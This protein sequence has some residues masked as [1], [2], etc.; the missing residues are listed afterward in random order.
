MLKVTRNPSPAFQA[1]SWLILI[2]GLALALL[3]FPSRILAIPSF[4]HL[5]PVLPDTWLAATVVI[6]FLAV[7]LKL[8]RAAPQPMLTLDG[9][10]FVYL[11]LA[12]ARI[13]MP[14]WLIV[15]AV[16][17]FDCLV[18]RRKTMAKH[19]VPMVGRALVVVALTRLVVIIVAPS[20]PAP[21]VP[22]IATVVFVAL[23]VAYN[24]VSLALNRVANL[25]AY[26]SQTI[27]PFDV[28]RYF[29]TGLLAWP[30]IFAETGAALGAM[31]PTQYLMACG[32]LLLLALVF[33][34]WQG[35]QNVE[36]GIIMR[37][38]SLLDARDQYAGS[39]SKDVM[40]LGVSF[41]TYLKWSPDSLY[42]AKLAC[43]LHD[44]GNAYVP[45]EIL[46]KPS[47]LTPDEY[48]QIKEH[49]IR[50]KEI[51]LEVL[52]L[53]HVADF[54]AD[55]HEWWDGGGYPRGAKGGEIALPARLIMLV[56]S[57]YAMTAQRP[58]RAGM[59]KEKALRIIEEETGRQFDPDLAKR[60][61]EFMRE[62]EVDLEL[63]QFHPHLGV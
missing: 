16:E 53:K 54:V 58:Y 13:P 55:S 41:A 4:P 6:L 40:D 18:L 45:A 30:L 56:D 2:V 12:A 42:R 28:P 22:L 60:F 37:L 23:T 5:P 46:S 36:Q 59:P 50:G 21:A 39:H 47:H 29:A 9:T 8:M 62:G 63:V 57:Y 15:I 26:V 61:I 49:V 32:L 11:Y 27:L 3:A 14:A 43:L 44:V 19:V 25:G 35:N 33:S 31:P 34:V 48:T 7:M 38:T 52:G 1:F 20:V 24:V 51:I 17:L 10:F